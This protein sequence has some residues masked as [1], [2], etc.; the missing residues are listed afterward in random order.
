MTE[1]EMR[2]SFFERTGRIA[3]I[4]DAEYFAFCQGVKME[5]EA[6]A[7]VCDELRE[8]AVMSKYASISDCHVARR[9]MQD[10]SAAIRGRTE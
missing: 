5:R 4:S 10:C 3:T 2:S 6:C 7:L 9:S 8:N 1:K